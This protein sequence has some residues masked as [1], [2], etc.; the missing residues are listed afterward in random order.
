[1]ARM[2]TICGKKKQM[3]NHRKLLRGHYNITGRRTFKPNLQ[4]TLHEGKKV[5]ACVNCIRTK[6][7]N[8]A[9]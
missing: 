1:M 5:L 2:C 9:A 3:G 8:A 7:K 6:A 4:T